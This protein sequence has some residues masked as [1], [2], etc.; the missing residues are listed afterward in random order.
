MRLSGTRE[1]DVAEERMSYT[2]SI[3][4]AA[5]AFT[6]AH[7]QTGRAG[8]LDAPVVRFEDL[9]PMNGTVSGSKRVELDAILQIHADPVAFWFQLHL[10][11][12]STVGTIGGLL[13]ADS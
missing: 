6:V 9:P 5:R 12:G 13:S 11:E 7:I 1:I 4:N 8:S 10:A 2:L 3:E